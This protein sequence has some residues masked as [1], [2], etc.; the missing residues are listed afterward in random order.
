MVEPCPAGNFEQ[1]FIHAHEIIGLCSLSKSK[2]SLSTWNSAR[3]SFAT[4]NLVLTVA[5]QSTKVFLY[6]AVPVKRYAPSAICTV[7]LVD[8]IEIETGVLIC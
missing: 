3:S 6:A 7:V 1:Q 8:R 2:P 5:V 4:C